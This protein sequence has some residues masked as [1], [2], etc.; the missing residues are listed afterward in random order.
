MEA[1]QISPKDKIILCTRSN[2][3][4]PSKY[5]LPPPLPSEQKRGII[6]PNGDLNWSCPCLGGLPYGPCGYQFREFFEC[7]HKIQDQ[8]NIGQE[9]FPK[10]ETMKDCFS[11]FPKLYPPDEDG[12]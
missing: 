11:K 8:N 12:L 3:E 2:H 9:C 10:F 5:E 7:I 4:V 6:L 1:I